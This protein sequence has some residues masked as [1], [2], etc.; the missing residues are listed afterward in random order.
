MDVISESISVYCRIR[1]K[2]TGVEHLAAKLGDDYDDSCINI[3]QNGSCKYSG[4][5]IKRDIS[6]KFTKCFEPST[7]QKEIYDLAAF[8]I[9]DSAIRGYNGT[10]LAYGPTNSGKTFTMKG[11]EDMENMGMIPRCMQHILSY[12]KCKIEIWASYLQIYCENVSDLLVSSSNNIS[13]SDQQVKTILQIREHSGTTYVDG[14]SRMKIESMDDLW[15]VLRKGDVNRTTAATNSN[16]TSSRSHAALIITLVSTDNGENEK[17]GYRRES[18]LILVDL[19]GSERASASEGRSYLRLEEAKSINLSLS[20]LGNCMNA[21]ADGKPHVPYRD[22]KL[23]RL[24]QGSLG[25]GSRTAVLLNI[26]PWLTKGVSDEPVLAALRFAARAAK[27]AVSAKVMRFIDYEALYN[28]VQVQLDAA[29]AELRQ[30]ASSAEQQRAVDQQLQA[31]LEA[32]REEVALLRGQLPA[33]AAT[34]AVAETA[35]DAGDSPPVESVERRLLKEAQAGKERLQQ[36]V[37]QLQK[38][39]GES[40]AEVRELQGEVGLERQR[41]LATV[42]DLTA[43]HTRHRDEQTAHE[44]RMAQLLAEL[45]DQQWRTEQLTELLERASAEA[46]SMVS[47]RQVAEME[48]LFLETVD[49]MSQRVQQ[50]EAERE[51]SRTPAMTDPQRSK[52]ME[53]V[54]ATAS[55]RMEAGGRI[56]RAKAPS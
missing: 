36:K 49:R 26:N 17:K 30:S 53:D 47:G 7:S 12:S 39:L 45:S 40:A 2:F 43:L 3:T 5:E 44:E 23:T 51:G 4:S 11:T 6:F 34:E 41:H 38:A 32:L 52:S 28:E 15:E 46:N 27:V 24:L 33:A 56:R 1:P 19:A 8:P 21:L 31:E 25:G 22:S 35:G 10:V 20:A 48:R 42:Q 37:Q 13:N 16:S 9:V 50:L 14:L 54:R 29:Q 55:L 18:S